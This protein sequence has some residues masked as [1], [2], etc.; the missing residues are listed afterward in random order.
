MPF[1]N[2]SNTEYQNEDYADIAFVAWLLLDFN[3][4]WA[5][6]VAPELGFKKKQKS[7]ECDFYILQRYKIA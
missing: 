1:K 4:L 7:R 3:Q 6:L 2:D 5:H